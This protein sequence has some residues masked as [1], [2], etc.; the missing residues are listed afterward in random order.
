M[1][2]RAGHRREIGDVLLIAPLRE[3]AAAIED[4]AHHGDD[5]D[6]R[7][8]EDDE[9]LA[10]L[11]L[12][13]CHGWTLLVVLTGGHGTSIRLTDSRVWLPNIATSGVIGSNGAWTRTRTN[14]SGRA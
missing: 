3:G 12:T 2:G 13:G 6:E 5:G 1:G 7:D 11:P 9:D 4:E 14:R 10:P 8:G